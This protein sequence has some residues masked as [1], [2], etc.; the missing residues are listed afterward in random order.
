ASQEV[1]VT[2]QSDM[3]QT[4][5]VTSGEV[6]PSKLIDELPIAGRDFNNLLRIQAGATQEQGGSQ[7]Y[8]GQHGLN[9]DFTPVSING[10]R[11]ESQSFLI[12]GLSDTDQYFTNAVNVPSSG[13]IEEFK[14]QN[15]L[16]SAEYG[17]GS[18]QINV[19]IKSGTNQFHGTV[20]DYL[21]NDA[22][23][24]TN[25]YNVWAHDV[26]GVPIPAKNALKQNQFGFTLGGPILVPKL[27]NGRNKSFFFYSYEGGRLHS[28]SIGQAL[29]PTMKERSGDFSDW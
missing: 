23:E 24:P 5:N 20:Y 18:A 16:Y 7:S 21:Q 10:A 4:D 19:A 9:N 22:F 14:V 12:D 8:W 26:N 2:S 13:A 17:Q 15:G 28:A 6:I 11:S 1:T 3:V 25:P 27:Y 29:V